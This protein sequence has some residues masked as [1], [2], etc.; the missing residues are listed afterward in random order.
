[1][2]IDAISIILNVLCNV[3]F[4]NNFCHL[5]IHFLFNCISIRKLKLA[6]IKMMR[7]EIINE[8]MFVIYFQVCH[9]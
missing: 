8:I 9:F 7:F 3:I 4:Q 6:V 1:M 2:K 5:N